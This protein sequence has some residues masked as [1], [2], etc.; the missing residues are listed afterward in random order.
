MIAALTSVAFALLAGLFMWLWWR[1]KASSAVFRTAGYRQG[2]E[3]AAKVCEGSETACAAAKATSWNAARSACAESIR[4][5]VK[6]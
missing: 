3:E 4:A 5:L 6:P 1:E 2:V